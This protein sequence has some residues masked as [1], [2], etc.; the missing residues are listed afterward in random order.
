I[1]D[2]HSPLRVLHNPVAAVET[3][4]GQA[5]SRP[6][7]THQPAKAGFVLFQPRIHS[8]GAVFAGSLTRRVFPFSPR[9]ASRQEFSPATLRQTPHSGDNQ[10]VK[11]P[12]GAMSFVPRR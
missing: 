12:G 6:P 11:L 8:P 7:P 10:S 9:P 4:P 3:A 1:S 5:R 2:R